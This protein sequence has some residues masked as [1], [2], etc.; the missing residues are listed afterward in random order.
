MSRAALFAAVALS[1][2]AAPA[3]AQPDGGQLFALQCKFCHDDDSLGP[4]L[5]GVADRKMGSTSF[6]YSAA[7][8]AKGEAGATWT[9]AELDAF[10]KSPTAYAPGTKMFMAV[11]Q[12]DNRAAIIAYLKTLKQPAP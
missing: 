6:D 8:K 2:V 5:T 1:L 12:D 4:N 11:P 9:D 10:L 3:L 7:L